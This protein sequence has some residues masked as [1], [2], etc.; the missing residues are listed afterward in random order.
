MFYPRTEYYTF[1]ELSGGRVFWG[2]KQKRYGRRYIET[3]T[4]RYFPVKE[5]ADN[6]VE[7]LK[8]QAREDRE[9]SLPSPLWPAIV[10]AILIIVFFAILNAI[11]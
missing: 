10:F 8:K 3:K 11:T 2:V 6:M 4:I 1:T 7:E 9:G 5:D